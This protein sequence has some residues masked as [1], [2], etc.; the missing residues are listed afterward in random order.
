[1]KI[2][3][4]WLKDYV[5]LEV[6]AEELAEKLTFS[7]TEIESITRVGAGLEDIVVGEIL[8]VDPHPN[9]DR[10]RLCRVSAGE[11]PVPVVCG[12]D[13]VTPGMKAAFAPVGATLPG[14]MKIKRTRIRGEESLGMLCAEDEL[15]LSDN[16]EGI[17]AL[18]DGA[19]PG[20]PVSQF[21]PPEDVVLELEI[22]WNR[23]DLLSVIGVAREVAALYDLPLKMPDISLVES[24]DTVES[25]ARV[26][27][28]DTDGCPNY[29]ARVICDVTQSPS[30][31]WMQRR[32]EMC[33]VRAINNLVDITNYVMLECGQP[34][35]AF[36]RALLDGHE[37]VVRRAKPGETLTTLDGLERSL[38]DDTL[39]IADAKR[40]V[41]LAGIMGGAGSEIHEGTSEIL[42]ESA[43]FDAP[44]IRR[45]SS[46]LGLSTE[47]SHRFERGVSVELAEWA[48]RRAAALFQN[49]AG[50]SVC[51]GVISRRAC[52]NTRPEVSMRYGRARS[53]IGLELSKEDMDGILNRLGFRP[54][55]S[56]EETCLIEVP[57][58]RLDIQI[59]ADLIE[60]IAR[61]HGIDQV[62]AG[63]PAV[64]MDP[65]ADES[66]NRAERKCR[67]AL[68]G[69]GLT[70]IIN[71]SFL[72][73]S[74]LDDFDGGDRSARLYLPNPVSRD[75]GVM[76]NSLFPQMVSTLGR[77]LA[78]QNTTLSFYEI[79][80]V[81]QRDSSAE[82]RESQVLAVG[83]MGPVGRPL[84]DRRRKVERE[85][86]L[87]WLKGVLLSLAKALN[88]P[89]IRFVSTSHT[90]FEDSACLQVE[91]DGTVCGT[92][93]LAAGSICSRWRMSNPLCLLQL[94]LDPLIRHVHD[95]PRV[96]EITVYPAVERD[97]AVVVDESVL[98]ETVVGA[99]RRDAPAELTGVE[100]FDIF[101]SSAVG[102]GKKSLAYTLTYRSLSKTLTD[103]E[104]NA[105]SSEVRRRLEEDVGAEIRDG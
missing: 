10:L 43:A 66:R 93:G 82:I 103:E 91:I 50:G 1:M 11:D 81:F 18:D 31:A 54:V 23:Q 78:H 67:Q 84:F 36:D 64:I 29:T 69:L 41:A 101:R 3:L 6:S 17:M 74:S 92:L 7:G 65:G 16:H 57:D 95:A 53:L 40:P 68:R 30:P 77:N 42:L 48:S 79:G 28:E 97:L 60:E 46:R 52:P 61:V 35:H 15:Q 8:S 39:V 63:V 83:M 71:Y 19:E 51:R 56:D 80:T 98:H 27:V 21:L 90:G 38:S 73:E 86:A 99:I 102:C 14:G 55:R 4:S 100:L 25:M 9:A 88:A 94:E 96:E 59:E 26:S 75:F 58:H 49:Y 32:L 45:T 47:S 70:E 13:N 104:V 22:T 33:G 44:C 5:D 87:M 76:R 20:S 2:P 89:E 12:A 37:I 34:L 24:E 62:P 105:Y 72:E 85:E